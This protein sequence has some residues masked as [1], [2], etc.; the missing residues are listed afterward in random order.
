[1]RLRLLALAPTLLLTTL[2]AHADSLIGDQVNVRYL[3]PNRN[4]VAVDFGTQTVTNGLTDTAFGDISLTFSAAQLTIT[5]LTSGAFDATA[6]NGFDVSFL[7]GAAI[8]A[9]SFDTM[10]SA[11]LRTGSNLRFTGNN[12]RLNLARTCQNCVGGESIVLDVTTAAAA[13][14][15]EPSSLALLGTGV[16]GIFGAMRRRFA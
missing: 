2:A 7:S 8:T 11:L 1:M 5:N 15:P 4:T 3:L 13:V 6:F 16:L 14:T 9:V 12:I 10:S